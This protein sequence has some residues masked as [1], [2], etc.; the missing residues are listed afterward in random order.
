MAVG[1]NC[2]MCLAKTIKDRKDIALLITRVFVGVIFIAHGLGKFKMGID[3]VTGFF[4]GLGLP[5]ASALAW[6]VT[7]V[8]L[9]GGAALLIGVLSRLAALLLSIIMVA[10]ILLVKIKVG[11]IAP[12]AAPGVGLELDLAL[13]AGLL[14]VLLQGPGQYSVDLRLLKKELC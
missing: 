4:Q 12:M 14:A 2:S 13:L 10:A 9:F 5:A 3:T 11:L 6:L 7:L 1:D 8:E